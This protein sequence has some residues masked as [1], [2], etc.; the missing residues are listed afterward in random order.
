MFN[1][2]KGAALLAGYESVRPLTPEEREALPIL[3]R[4]AAMRFFGTRL[5]DW[6]ER[7]D[8]AL[9]QRKD[10]LEYAD[11]LDFHRRARNAQDYGA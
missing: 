2:T 8:G 5:H 4:G 9:V 3:A 6:T 10:P 7:H 1:L 11:K